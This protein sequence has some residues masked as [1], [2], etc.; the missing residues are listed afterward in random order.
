LSQSLKRT[1]QTSCLKVLSFSSSSC[2]LSPGIP[3]LQEDGLKKLNKTTS[4]RD[5]L[6]GEV[7]IKP[8]GTTHP[9]PNVEE[10]RDHD[11]GDAHH[12]PLP[13]LTSVNMFYKFLNF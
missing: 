8:G 10:E 11:A 6:S 9:V 7:K 2:Y 3:E 12:S 1:V 5:V 13:H 4:I